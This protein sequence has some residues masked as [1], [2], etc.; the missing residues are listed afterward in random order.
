MSTLGDAKVEA[1]RRAQEMI[2]P[3]MVPIKVKVAGQERVLLD[4][5]GQVVFEEIY[6]SDREVKTAYDII[7]TELGEPTTVSKTDIT[8][9]GQPISS[10]VIVIEDFSKPSDGAETEN[11]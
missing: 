10:N 3:R 1:I 7:K 2:R 5:D 11:Q 9:K 6:P 4:A 8:T